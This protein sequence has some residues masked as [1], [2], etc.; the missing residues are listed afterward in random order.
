MRK[1]SLL[2]SVGVVVFAVTAHAQ[3]THPIPVGEPPTPGVY[4]PTL[5]LSGDS[6]ASAVDK[7]PASLGYLPSWSGVYLHSDLDDANGV[8][9]GEGD[10]FFVATPVPLLSM[11]AVGAGVQL[12][13]PPASFGLPNENKFSLAFAF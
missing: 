9:G 5:G 2:V 4:N 8:V 13:R 12:L 11:I 6:D 1:A 3:T 7:N 10:G